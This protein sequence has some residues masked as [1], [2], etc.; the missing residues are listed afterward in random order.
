MV[1]LNKQALVTE[2]GAVVDVL[3]VVVINNTFL[4]TEQK[5]FLTFLNFPSTLGPMELSV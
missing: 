1:I 2:A 3:T 5:E 4:I